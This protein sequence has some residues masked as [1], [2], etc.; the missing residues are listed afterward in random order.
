MAALTINKLKDTIGAEVLGLDADL[1]A[2]DARLGDQLSAAL[3]DSG[4]LVFREMFLDP[5]Q[6]VAFAT[7]FGEVD[8]RS[9][10]DGIFR[11]T[12]NPDRNPSAEYLRGTVNWHID[13]TTLPDGQNPQKATVLTAHVLADDGGQTEWASTYAGYDA[14]TPAEQARCDSFRVAHSVGATMR[15]VTVDPTPEQEAAWA[16]GTGREQPLVWRHRSGRKSLVLG[17]TA[18]YVVGMDQAQGRALLD[19]LLERT[20]VPEKVYRHEWSVGD[21]VVW[22]NRGVVHRVLPYAADS[23][24]EMLRTVLLG[25]EPIG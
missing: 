18:D 9:G 16:T 20:T 23:S 21:A 24:R 7:L 15:R 25:D 12:L 17:G 22:D 2:H 10:V 19:E 8:F 5:A 4:V 14:L 13:G 3:E 1:I 11:I 6:Q